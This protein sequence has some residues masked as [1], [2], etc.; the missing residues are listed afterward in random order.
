MRH[1]PITPPHGC[2]CF[3]GCPPQICCDSV[4]AQPSSCHLQ[5]GNTLC[6]QRLPT[7]LSFRNSLHLLLLSALLQLSPEQSPTL[8]THYPRKPPTLSSQGPPDRWLGRWALLPICISYGGHRVGTGM[9]GAHQCTRLAHRAELMPL[10]TSRAAA[11]G[12]ALQAHFSES[13]P[14]PERQQRVEP[15]NEFEGEGDISQGPPL[16]DPPSNNSQTQPVD[17][18]SRLEHTNSKK[19]VLD[20]YGLDSD[21]IEDLLL[22]WLDVITTWWLCKGKNI[23]TN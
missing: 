17:F 10:G 5:E 4:L 3:Q 16:K 7:H 15:R 22:I 1:S 23:F 11:F 14:G 20:Q 18:G 9:A 8:L 13:C 12:H 6:W 19:I 2:R 21:S